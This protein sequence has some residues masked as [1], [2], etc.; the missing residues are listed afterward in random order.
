MSPNDEA[1]LI[2]AAR[3]GDSRAYA[4][5][6][7]AHQQAIRGF[8]RRFA[9]HWADADDLAQ[10]AFVT[11]WRK[12]ARFEGRSSFRSWVS[13]IGFRI[14][15]DARRSHGRAQLRDSE[16]LQEQ[17]DVEGV[18]PVEDRIA[19]T[20]AMAKLPD[21]QRAVVAL[22]LGEG[23]S[24]SEASEILKLP[25][26]TVKSHVTRGRERLWRALETD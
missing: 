16:W 22:C 18:P 26:G 15:R 21:E 5:L 12:L 25:L 19:V 17:S 6:V 24:H 7:D 3:R 14:A 10:E 11:A 2:A 13:G 8:L 20:R 1:R 23:F 4:A 9:G